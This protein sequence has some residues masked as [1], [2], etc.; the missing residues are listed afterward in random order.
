[1]LLIERYHNQWCDS[2][3]WIMRHEAVNQ[4]IN[5]LTCMW[6]MSKNVIYAVVCVPQ[7]SHVKVLG[8]VLP[9]LPSINFFAVD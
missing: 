7:V 9:I 6:S 5:G 2:L 1:M 4:A 8:Q 3:Y